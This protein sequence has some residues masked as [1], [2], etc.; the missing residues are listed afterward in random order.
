MM[1]GKLVASAEYIKCT[2]FRSQL[3]AAKGKKYY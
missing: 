1:P 2:G 3:N